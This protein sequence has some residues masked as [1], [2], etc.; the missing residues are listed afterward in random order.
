MNGLQAIKLLEQ[1]KMI[2]AKEN[3]SDNLII[4]KIENGMVYYR[5]ES[6]KE[7]NKETMF[8]FNLEYEEHIP[9]QNLIGWERV[10]GCMCYS[11]S[12]NGVFGTID[13]RYE[14][15][16]ERY[17]KANYFSTEEKAEE[18]K[19]KQMVFRK[20]QRF[21][22]ENGGNEIDWDDVV[23]AKWCI[24]YNHKIKKLYACDCYNI[25]YQCV[26]FHSKGV[27][28]KAIELFHD[29]LIQYFTM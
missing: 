21:S 27:A 4:Y 14:K 7:W 1:G 19:F 10:E 3:E 26:Y 2:Q 28:E 5:Y 12:S 16:N 23:Q 25:R 11:I 15:D 24:Y 20:L 18:I 8:N 22:D 9:Q 13:F 6:R 17:K 29:D